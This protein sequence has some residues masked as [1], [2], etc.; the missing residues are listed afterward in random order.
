MMD[1]VNNEITNKAI[2]E[3]IATRDL[4]SFGTGTDGVVAFI[5]AYKD[6]IV[7]FIYQNYLSNSVD[8][9]GNL[10]SV[11]EEYRKLKI[12]NSK[13]L[14]N[15]VV[16]TNEGITINLN[17]IKRDYK[18]KVYLANSEAG[19]AYKNRDGLKPF[20]SSEDPFT[21]EE[22]YIRYVLERAYQETQGLKDL[23]LNQVSLMNVYNPNALTKNSEYSYTKMI[24]DLV[25]E[26]PGL[27]SEYPVLEQLSARVSRDSYLLT[28]NDRDV[29]D[30]STKSQ[31]AANIRALGN[32]R[33]QK[34]KGDANARISAIFGLLPK[35]AVYQHGNGI[36]PFGLEQVV[37]Q[38]T[39]ITA[40]K[41]AGDL[42]KVNYWN[43][44]TLNL[45]FDKLVSSENNR[46]LFK[47]FLVT[48]VQIG[49]P[50]NVKT[51]IEPS[52]DPEET[53]PSSALKET[54]EEVIDVKEDV[55]PS[56]ESVTQKQ[57]TEQTYPEIKF[58]NSNIQKI[59][60]GT[61][62]ITSTL[63]ALTED[64]EFYTMDNGAVVRVKYLG[65]ATLDNKTDIVT[66]TNKETGLKTTRTL[67]QYAKAE[68]F[69]SAA[70]FKKNN[71]L[72]ASFINRGQIRQVYQIEPV[73]L[74][75]DVPEGSISAE[76]NPE[77]TEFNTY[78]AENDNVFPKEFNPS[79]GRRYLLND[80]NLY[81]L[82]SPD[83]K[84]MYLRNV[85]LRT[86]KV[87]T[88]PEVV[89]PVSEKRK[90]QS[91]R[92]IKEMINLMSLD[93]AMAEDGYNIF[94]LMEDIRNATSMTE[95][96]RI[97]EIIRKYTC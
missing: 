31:Y 13:A 69:N 8:A 33:I 6:A 46:K 92:D 21:T 53:A 34:V 56:V 11:P 51:A 83:G 24:L 89:V 60:N 97:E 41:N 96:E 65:E 43:Q 32:P 88:V 14:N 55:T 76:T 45:I 70:D 22:Q 61:K 42:F 73:D 95:V 5:D 68:G 17:N 36:T 52:L 85:N 86:G 29:A 30:G 50:A 94:Q 49:N 47:N 35:I 7:T 77:I 82:V 59:M 2:R 75:R 4:S 72:N 57:A 84:T 58:N 91:I 90:E 64:S 15:D 25:D 10:I 23:Q 38:E 81:D 18:E 16:Y 12:T 54:T 9:K 37:P 62:I 93:L 27:R 40:T 87:E 71:L 26:F 44:K 79:N 74:V 20:N 80:N 1:L 3:I 48:P 67:D 19:T 63:N 39:V 78:L 66:I 28:L